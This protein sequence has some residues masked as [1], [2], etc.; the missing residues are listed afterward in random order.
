VTV[1]YAGYHYIEQ[2]NRQLCWA[3]ISSNIAAIAQSWGTNQII[4]KQLENMVHLLFRIRHRYEN[5]NISAAIYR[6]RMSRLQRSWLKGL[7]QGARDCHTPRYKNRCA[8]LR[9]H[10]E[11]CRMFLSNEAIPLSNN[12]AVRSLRSYVLWRK[13]S[14]GVWS[15]RGEQF[16]QRILTIV[17]SAVNSVLIPRNSCVLSCAV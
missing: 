14:Y 8:L 6:W 12:A 15:H 9:K 11:M 3:H 2:R 16:R 10:D 5:G 1:Q 4:G 13:G 17:E 7:A